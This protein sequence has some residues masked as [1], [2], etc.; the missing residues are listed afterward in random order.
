MGSGLWQSKEELFPGDSSGPTELSP[1][2]CAVPRGAEEQAGHSAAAAAGWQRL[3]L[4][5]LARVP[6]SRRKCIAE[7]ATANLAADRGGQGQRGMG[8]SA[9]PQDAGWGLASLCAPAGSKQGVSIHQ[10]NFLR[11]ATTQRLPQTLES[12]PCSK[13]HHLASASKT[14]CPT[15]G[16]SNQRKLHLG[17]LQSRKRRRFW[18]EPPD[19]I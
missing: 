18:T 5:G 17:D 19:S 6:H 9:G 3:S 1:P 8:S 11:E 13:G 15:S 14:P 12:P 7:K 2:D 16:H 4:L 10:I